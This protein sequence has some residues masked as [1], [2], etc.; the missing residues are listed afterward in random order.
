MAEEYEYARSDAAGETGLP[1]RAFPENCPYDIEEILGLDFYPQAAG[2][3][4]GQ[5]D[6]V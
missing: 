1:A 3:A 6:L 5:S 4:G 2:S